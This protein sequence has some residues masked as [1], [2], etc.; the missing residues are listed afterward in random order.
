MKL[1]KMGMSSSNIVV[2]TVTNMS[3]YGLDSVMRASKRFLQSKFDME[4]MNVYEMWKQKINSE[5]DEVRVSV[6]IREL[7][8]WRDKCD[9]TFLTNDGCQTIINDLCKNEFIYVSFCF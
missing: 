2:K 6:Q 1:I 4:E 3:I 8:E 7:C 9:C 5:S